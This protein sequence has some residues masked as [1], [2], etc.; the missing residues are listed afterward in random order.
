MALSSTKHRVTALIVGCSLAVGM[1]FVRPAGALADPVDDAQVLLNAAEAQMSHI[2]EDYDETRAAIDELQAEIA[3]A[4]SATL[5]AQ[6]AVIDG[7]AD[8][9]STAAF[10]YR[11]S[12]AS[13]LIDVLFGSENLSDLVKNLEYFDAVMRSQSDE[14]AAQQKR[15][16]DFEQIASSLNEKKDEEMAAL[17]RLQ[18]MREEAQT[19]VANAEAA[20]AD[21]QAQAEAQRL[22]ALRQQALEIEAQA[23]VAEEAQPPAP[24][25]PSEAQTAGEE[26]NAAQEAPK[27]DAEQQTADNASS[28]AGVEAEASAAE[29]GGGADA[30]SGWYT[31]WATAYGGSGITNGA[32]T[33]GGGVV[34]DTSMGVAVPMAWPNYSS[35][36]GRTVEIS[37]NGTT[38]YATINDCGGMGGGAVSLDLQPGVYKALGFDTEYDWGNREVSYRIL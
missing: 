21:A 36:Y 9:A 11:T 15:V 12:P 34:T 20:L 17:E 31:G 6:Q 33:A 13:L 29:T 8:L 38:V 7:R 19:V 35:Y 23:Q 25:Q 24:A 22:E 4:S 2:S 37:Y 18:D 14:V 32:N 5:D 16:A 10:A 26:A 30:S 28:D 27:A 3:E 1:A